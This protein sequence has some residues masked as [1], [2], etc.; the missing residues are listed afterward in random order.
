MKTAHLSLESRINTGFL[1]AFPKEE[2]RG[3][4]YN[5]MI[6]TRKFPV[7]DKNKIKL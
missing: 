1:S 3:I 7:N 5:W 2:N 6:L 4:V